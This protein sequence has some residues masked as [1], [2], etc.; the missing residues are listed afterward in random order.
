MG[1]KGIYSD[2]FH[3]NL[4]NV[5]FDGTVADPATFTVAH[6]VGALEIH[7]GGHTNVLDNVD[8]GAYFQELYVHG[9]GQLVIE[10]DLEF[11]FGE[12]YIDASESEGGLRVDVDSLDGLLES[13]IIYGS[14]ARDVITLNLNSI[15]A[16]AYV[17]I[18][19]GFGR[20][21][22]IIDD[23][24]NA[25][26]GSLITGEDLTVQ[27]DDDA[28]LRLADVGGVDN[29]VIGADGGL[30]LTLEQVTE[31]GIGNF[32][33]AHNT[34]PVLTIEVSEDAV[35]SEIIDLTAL[36]SDIRLAF[37]LQYDATLTLTAEE[38]HTYLTENAVAGDGSVVITDAGL[39]FNENDDEINTDNTD[40]NG[41]ILGEGFGTIEANELGGELHI[42]RSQDGYERP[43]PDDNTDT[44][45]INSTGDTPVTIDGLD[46]EQVETLII[47]G[48]QDVIFTDTV[49]LDD[50]FTID[51]S[52]LTGALTGLT[53]ENFDKITAD[54]DPDNWGQIIGNGA[55]GVRID[56]ML[57]GHVAVEGP[58]SG[59]PS[60]GVEQYVV[61]DMED[62]GAP[63]SWDFHLCDNT[64]DLK[65][66][67][68]QGMSGEILTLTN[69][70]WG[71][72][73]PTILFEGDG[74]ANWDELPK[75][76]GNPDESNVG[77]IVAEYFFDGAPAN[78]LI[79]NQGVAPGLTTEGE[80]RPIV[81]DGIVVDNAASLNI[82]VEDGNAVITDIT[83]NGAGE[84]LADITMTSAFDVTLH[85]DDDEDGVLDSIDASGVVGTATLV[86]DDDQVVDL[87]STELTD[88]D[89]ITLVDDAEVTLTIEQI[90]AIGIEE[91][92]HQ[93]TA[94]ENEATL[95]IAG[96]AEEE[97]S[98]PA[99]SA[100]G[101]N[102]G[103][104]TIAEEDTVTLHV[105]TDLT[106]ATSVIVLED[107]VV[108]MTAD[109]FMQF[110]TYDADGDLTISPIVTGDGTINITGLTQQHID[111]G[112]SLDQVT[113]TEGEIT[114]AEDVVFDATTDLGDAAIELA[115]GQTVNFATV[116]QASAR[117]VNVA[118]GATDTT[119]EYAF[120]TGNDGLATTGFDFDGNDTIG[121]G[122]DDP[123]GNDEE[124]AIDTSN[125]SSDLTTLKVNSALLADENVE[126]VLAGLDSDI[127]VDIFTPTVTI[128]IDG[129]NR[130]VVAEPDAS[131]EGSLAFDDLQGS[132]RVETL[133]ITLQGGVGIAA[134]N[135]DSTYAIDVAEA[136][137]GIAGFQKLTINSE[138]DAANV[139][140]DDTN[141]DGDILATDNDLLDVEIN[142]DQD[143]IINGTIF[144]TKEGADD[145]VADG[146]DDAEA[147]LTLNGAGDITIAALDYTDTDVDTLT[148]VNNATGTVNVPG[149]SPAIE[150]AAGVDSGMDAQTSTLVLEG[151]GDINFG[152]ADDPETELVDE[153]NSGFAIDALTTI[154]AGEM[155]GDLNL[156]IVTGTVG[157]EE[158]L[159]IIGSQ[160]VTT[161]TLGAANDNNTD[162]LIAEADFEMNAQADVTIDLSGSDA[163]SSVTLTEDAVLPDMTGEA[164]DDAGSLTISAETLVIEGNVDLS[165]FVNSDDDSTL[166]LA[167]VTNIEL[168]EG[169]SVKMTDDQWDALTTD[170]Q[171]AIAGD[172]T[173]LVVDADFITDNGSDLTQFRGITEIQIDEDVDAGALTLTMTDDQAAVAT[174]GTFDGDGVFTAGTWD[175]ADGA[176][177]DDE[178]V[179]AGNFTNLALSTVQVIIDS[180]ADLTGF[181]AVDEFDLAMAEETYAALTLTNDQVGALAAGDNDLSSNSTADLDV[182]NGWADASDLD[183]MADSTIQI[184]AQSGI[185]GVTGDA[186]YTTFD[187]AVDITREADG[188]E[189]YT[190]TGYAG[191]LAIDSA[192][193]HLV[194]EETALEELL[195]D[196]ES[197]EFTGVGSLYSTEQDLDGDPETA[198]EPVALEAT[199]SV[200]TFTFIASPTDAVTIEDFSAAA[201]VD[202][203]DLPEALVDTGGSGAGYEEIGG[204]NTI[205][206]NTG[207]AVYTG[208]I[209][210]ADAAGIEDLFDATTDNLEFAV[211][212]DKL[213]LAAD[214]G[215]DTYIWLIEDVGGDS[216]FTEADGDTAEL[217]VTLNGVTDATT[218]A[219]A[220]FAD[221]A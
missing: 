166:D 68:L 6:N 70:P 119:V 94:D 216:E 175:I 78:V 170:Q 183:Q 34:V 154:D 180:D 71:A 15:E 144:F 110:G 135:V 41:D 90:D 105:D 133:D 58:D 72:V 16:G 85:L 89:G 140:G 124:N 179:A 132:V 204:A 63:A 193:N 219:G 121:D 20:D 129:T 103:S 196:A 178:T 162:D 39:S 205:A 9:W 76:A 143:L 59:L 123:V 199:D 161:L 139:L 118:D 128:A 30:L 4:H 211:A 45:I 75:A 221:F 97:F 158:T 209:A 212:G 114:L 145:G 187:V 27:V 91:I 51:F 109:Q 52:D 61:V 99:G 115:T 10:D 18:D 215:A 67:G 153:S 197:V 190:V 42:I 149:A 12:A 207:I 138:G 33:A 46:A 126:Q 171:D 214:D 108:T 186:T 69:V 104:V 155:T 47:M 174:T 163:G 195:N 102:L 176:D 96:L 167:G 22:L 136:T 184:V 181:V 77:T 116:E 49:L 31:L 23:E 113:A 25:G 60:S 1:Y 57:E 19:T 28:D 44:L 11:A 62:A 81:V 151:S 17:E 88:I 3:L 29:F 200:D 172:G 218:L 177:E 73:N 117:E 65:V 168:A 189:T 43:L 152:T 142:A 182:G 198:A 74:Y 40:V 188:S 130:I 191:A 213:Y 32:S 35:L 194:P 156:G 107:T 53:I 95:N 80:A 217:I 37:S 14:Q 21:T 93:E 120:I 101:V 192:N 122:V 146:I 56:V 111:D 164:A 148:I 112:F 92:V 185:D 5:T 203:L 64:Q 54:V 13:L 26:A 173:T 98:L 55:E 7:S 79:T 201:E 141:M 100:E 66:I 165:G 157:A 48:D 134:D 150:A 86:I 208:D 210:T 159:S 206:A 2:R 24:I 82:T 127:T 125:Y 8:F 38:L 160:G 84:G 147:T 36:D 220:N 83:D 106:G 50:N 202:V 137:A 131:V 169:A 87:S